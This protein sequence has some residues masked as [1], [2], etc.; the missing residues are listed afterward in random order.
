MYA[1]NPE[2]ISEHSTYISPGPDQ[3]RPFVGQFGFAAESDSF[4]G[5]LF[6][7]PIMKSREKSKIYSSRDPTTIRTV[8][9]AL[10]EYYKDA[11]TALV[12]LK[13]IKSIRFQIQDGKAS[14]KL[15]WE[16]IT[17]RPPGHMIGI[18][19]FKIKHKILQQADF[20]TTETEWMV[21]RSM[22]EPHEIPADVR[23]T[24]E[25][26]KLEARCGIAAR[27]VPSQLSDP[28]RLFLGAPTDHKL[29]L[30]VH[31]SAVCYPIP[32]IHDLC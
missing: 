28:G 13:N 14:N 3:L 9:M 24:C 10:T 12:F 5:T 20:K 32:V 18:S 21:A 26:H 30:P 11:V 17:E 16:V 31:V 25:R 6:R 2:I 4:D 1:S 15:Q 22:L 27:I 19:T 8:E 29:G 23:V 7:F